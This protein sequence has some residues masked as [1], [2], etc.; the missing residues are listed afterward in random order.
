MMAREP[1]LVAAAPQ[2]QASNDRGLAMIRL[3][4]NFLYQVGAALHPLQSI[5]QNWTKGQTWLALLSAENWL[6]SLLNRSVY[7]LQTSWASG[8]QLLSTMRAISEEYGKPE[9][10]NDENTP[11]VDSYRLSSQAK[12]FE[13]ILTAE[14]QL[15][16]M[17]L[18]EPKGGFD[19]NQL[20]EIGTT[21]FPNALT[22]RVPETLHDAKAAARCIAFNLPTAAAFHLH[23]LQELVL[24]RY[25]DTVTNGK[26]RPEKRNIGAYIDALKNAGFKDQKVFGALAGLKNFHRNPVLHPDDR[27][28]DIE[29]ALALL[30]NI[31][32][33]L[34]YMLKALPPEP[35]KLTAPPANETQALEDKTQQA[36]DGP[37]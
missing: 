13:T 3:D 27:L 8:N 4:G 5:N 10:K 14:L 24:R 1:W 2:Q 33:V 23:R 6:D 26:P 20:T 34:T 36:S 28:E 9:T 22:A 17:Y 37:T 29:E 12:T 35:L 19:L 31:N 30:G 25:Y 21:I 7:R 11:W 15:G 18:V 32:T 16:Q